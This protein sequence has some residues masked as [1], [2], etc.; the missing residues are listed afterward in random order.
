VENDDLNVGWHPLKI[1][2][3]E[4]PKYMNSVLEYEIKK[5]PSLH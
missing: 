3:D 5:N 1:I 4:N 2:I